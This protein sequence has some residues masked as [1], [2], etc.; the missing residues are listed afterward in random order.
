MSPGFVLLAARWLLEIQTCK[1]AVLHFKQID[2][3][4]E[5]LTT[6]LWYSQ[7]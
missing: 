3:K 6:S 5:K 7:N 2:S 4:F 1:D